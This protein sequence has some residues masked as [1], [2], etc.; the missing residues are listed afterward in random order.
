MKKFQLTG[1]KIVQTAL[2]LVSAFYL[3]YTLTHYKIGTIRMPKEGFMPVII[4]VAMTGISAYLMLKAFMGK[5]DAKNVKLNISWWRLGLIVAISLLYS[6]T[7]TAVGYPLGTFL[8]MFGVFKLSKLE[9]WIKPLVISL[10]VAIG[11]YLIFKVGL[12][13]LLPAGFLGL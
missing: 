10:A 5:G 11:F 1:E 2:L 13:V 3:Y 9:G 7:L 8:Y 4:G 6:I 12:G